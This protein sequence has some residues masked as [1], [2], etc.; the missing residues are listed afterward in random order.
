[1]H[2]FI[3]GF[4]NPAPFLIFIDFNLDRP[5]C[6]ISLAQRRMNYFDVVDSNEGC[7]ELICWALSDRGNQ[8]LSTRSRNSLPGLKCGA[9]LAGTLT[10][11][12]VFG[13]RPFLA[14]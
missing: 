1:M 6:A 5:S 9:Y 14:G 12:P 11:T 13:F 4:K 10:L 2:A 7:L 8:F 3:N